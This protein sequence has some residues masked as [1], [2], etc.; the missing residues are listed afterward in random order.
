M[1][2]FSCLTRQKEKAVTIKQ[3]LFYGH[4]SINR[5]WHIEN[6]IIDDM[7]LL[8]SGTV[9]SLFYNMAGA[10]PN[11]ATTF[12][13]LVH[14]WVNTFYFANMTGLEQGSNFL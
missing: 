11:G 3:A 12:F 13:E 7:K 10:K 1:R 5:I 8:L 6:I 2:T 14:N 4:T 9:Q